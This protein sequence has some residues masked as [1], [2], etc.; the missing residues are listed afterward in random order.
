[1][2]VGRFAPS[3]SGRMH[4]GNLFTAL[5]AWLSVRSQNGKMLLRIEDLDPDRSK[6]AYIDA[7]KDDLQWLGLDWDEEMPLQSTRS[8]FYGRAFAQ[9]PTYPCYCSRNELHDA[10]A[11]HASDGK[12]IYAGTCRNLTDDERKAKIRKPAWRVCVPDRE[13]SFTDGIFGD[14]KENLAK[15]CGDFIVR[16]SDGVYAYQLAVV[17]D[18]ADGGVTEVVRGCDLLNSTPRQI[19]LYQALHKPVPQFYH[20]P[21][22]VAPDGKRLSKREKSLDMAHLRSRFQ[23]EEL[24]G[25]L[26]NLAGLTGENNPVSTAELIELFSWEKI[27]KDPIVVNSLI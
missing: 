8:E 22:L 18:D 10:S 19:W 15:E 14:Q 1:M 2:T 17:C 6:Q 20:V 9:L 12:F 11:P 27:G 24:L 13:I 5:L 7:L 16:R 4:L 3:P 25:I 26:S 23:P 21:L